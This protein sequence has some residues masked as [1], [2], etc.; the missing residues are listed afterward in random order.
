MAIR[1]L[2]HNRIVSQIDE[3]LALARRDNPKL[4]GVIYFGS[5]SRGKK[6]PRDLD[7]ILLFGANTTKTE[8]KQGIASFHAI[9]KQ[10]YK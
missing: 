3:T 1:N 7:L 9:I 10:E 2:F 5:F 8:V 4:A 6:S